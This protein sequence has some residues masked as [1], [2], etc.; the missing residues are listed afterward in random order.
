MGGKWSKQTDDENKERNQHGVRRDSKDPDVLA[1][2]L[3]MI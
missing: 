3:V 1:R 2:A